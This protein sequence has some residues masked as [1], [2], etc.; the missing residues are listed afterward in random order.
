MD[1]LPAKGRKGRVPVLPKNLGLS[2]ETHAWWREIWHSPMALMWHSSM[3][4][5]L[6]ELAILRD[7]IL[8]DGKASLAAEVRLRSASSGLLRRA[9]NNF[10]G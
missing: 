1:Q 4:P 2:K 3:E 6:V 8:L 9:G 7:R 5:A 10:V